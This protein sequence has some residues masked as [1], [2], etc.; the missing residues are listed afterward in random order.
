MKWIPFEFT[1]DPMDNHLAPQVADVPIERISIL[2]PVVFK[3]GRSMEAHRFP[4]PLKTFINWAPPPSKVAA[5][6][7]D[8]AN[9]TCKKNKMHFL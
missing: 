3:S 6:K 7:P 1:F 2:T 4:T 9:A 8:G 5:A